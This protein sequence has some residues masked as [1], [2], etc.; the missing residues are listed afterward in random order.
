MAKFHSL[1]VSE[2]RRETADCVSVAF[3]IPAELKAEYQYIQGQY[4]TLKLTVNGEEIRRSYSLCSSP[5]ADNEWRI[6]IKKVKDGRG[7]GFINDKLKAGDSMEVMTPMGNFYTPLNASNKKNYVLFAGGS[8]IT[9][10]LS[11][12]KTILKAEPQSTLQLFYG[13]RDEASAIF[14]KVID[15]LAA[16]SSGRLQV[17]HI[18]EHPAAGVDALYKGM[19]TREKTAEL[20]KKHLSSKTDNEYFICGPGPMMENVKASLQEMKV[21]EKRLHI[22]YFTAVLEAVNKAEAMN[23]SA[24]SSAS[25]VTVIMDGRETEFELAENGQVILDAALDEGVDV[26]YACKG[27]VCC[28]CRA[29]LIEG[30]VKMDNNYALT[31]G[32]VKEGYI[33]TCQSH[34]LTPKVVVNYDC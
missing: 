14:K 11:I 16:N 12:I 24:S 33:L 13:N 27:A 8:G 19:L 34:P 4:L 31:D 5:V 26:P 6:A 1:R 17:V 10:M 18:M 29:K 7:S 25:K 22:E 30:K 9:P 21:D 28:T 2:V 15:E 32:E 3:E 23:T 20:L